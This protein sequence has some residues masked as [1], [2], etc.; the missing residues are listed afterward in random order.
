MLGS[1]HAF[2]WR[3][4]HHHLFIFE[5]MFSSTHSL[6]GNYHKNFGS[7]CQ[8]GPSA[9][10]NSQCKNQ[11]KHSNLECTHTHSPRN[12]RDTFITTCTYKYSHNKKKTLW[13]FLVLWIYNCQLQILIITMIAN[14][15]HV[16]CMFQ[17][18]RLAATTTN[19]SSH[20]IF[21]STAQRKMER[22]R[23]TIYF[24][25]CMYR[26]LHNSRHHLKYSLNRR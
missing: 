26:T 6:A 4:H 18:T 25:T 15:I 19:A 12:H 21:I 1:V 5:N 23:T 17:C 14:I 22:V 13:T 11:W 7:W 24:M 16:C 9:S 8:R 3:R 2:H 20:I 10:I